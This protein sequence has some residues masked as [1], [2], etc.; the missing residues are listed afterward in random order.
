MRLAQ[1]Q[2]SLEAD[3]DTGHAWQGDPYNRFTAG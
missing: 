3:S 2:L 1:P